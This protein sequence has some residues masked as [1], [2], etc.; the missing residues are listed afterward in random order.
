M[1]SHDATDC[2]ICGAHTDYC[3]L[4]TASGISIDC[5]D[6]QLRNTDDLSHLR[7]PEGNATP[8]LAEEVIVDLFAGPGGWDEALAS[9]G[10]H[11]VLGI[12]FDE[13]CCRT[14][15]AAGHA[16]LHANVAE[17]D[18]LDFA[19][20]EGLIASPPCQAWSMAGARRGEQDRALVYRVAEQLMAGRDIRADARSEA[21]DERSLLVVEPLRWALALRP[22]WIA[23][24]QVEP[25][26]ELWKWMAEQLRTVGYSAWAGVLSAERYGVPQTRRRAFLVA[27][28]DHAVHPPSPTHQRFVPGEPATHQFTLEGELLPWVSMAEALGWTNGGGWSFVA[29]AQRNACVRASDEPAPTIKGGHDYNDRRWIVDTGNTRGGAR[30]EGRKRATDEP[31]PVVTTRADQL[32]WRDEEPDTRAWTHQRPATTVQGDPRIA[33]PGWRGRPDDYDAD[34][35]YVGRRSMDDAIRVTLEQALVLQGFRPDYPVQG[36]KSDRFKQVGNAVPPP[37]AA[38]V[39]GAVMPAATALRAAARQP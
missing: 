28:L 33:Q 21:A 11:D 9:L 26:L 5:R 8:E 31:A 22:R 17:L 13:P 7:K 6:L 32:E 2:P 24:E 3:H 34:G 20:I 18:P 36:T 1:S 27:S 10:R 23:C 37:L 30:P 35:N 16:T 19:G 15:A 14:R 4:E 25:V 39:L 38:A 12:E 29:N